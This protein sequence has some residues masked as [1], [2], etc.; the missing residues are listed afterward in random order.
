M[1]SSGR[2]LQ[3]ISRITLNK[4]KKSTVQAMK[5][6]VG[7]KMLQSFDAIVNITNQTAR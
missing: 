2:Q 4:H 6:K 7:H 5:V 3:D 1:Q